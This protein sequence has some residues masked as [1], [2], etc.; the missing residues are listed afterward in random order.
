MDE[1]G[2]PIL[3]ALNQI[4][5]VLQGGVMGKPSPYA[6][7][8]SPRSGPRWQQA[9]Y[10]PSLMES[11][12]GMAPTVPPGWHSYDAAR[13]RQNSEL[14]RR[15]EATYAEQ[16]PH[17]QLLAETFGGMIGQKDAGAFFKSG[18]GAMA[19]P[20]ASKALAMTGFPSLLLQINR[21]R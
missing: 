4:I 12:L 8:P 3:E 2:Q 10:T 5:S 17:L 18:I 21:G 1:Y 20:Y 19:A 9:Q 7:G 15:T 14:N 6:F 13:M 16:N 11:F